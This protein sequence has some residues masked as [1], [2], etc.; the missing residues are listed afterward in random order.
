MNDV[1]INYSRHKHISVKKKSPTKPIDRREITLLFID[2]AALTYISTEK[3]LEF[4]R[5]G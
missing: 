4:V 3:W 1:E 2:I 5:L